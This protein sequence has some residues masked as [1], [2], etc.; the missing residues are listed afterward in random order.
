MKGY[1]GTPDCARIINTFHFA[2]ASLGAAL[3]YVRIQHRRHIP[4]REHEMSN[5][6]IK[7]LDHEIG[8]LVKMH[9]PEFATRDGKWLSYN[10][11]AC[12]LWQKRAH[13]N[14][15]DSA[16]TRSNGAYSR[17]HLVGA[18]ISTRLV[19]TRQRGFRQTHAER[20]EIAISVL[21]RERPTFPQPHLSRTQRKL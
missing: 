4:S 15:Q 14:W 6:E 10:T 20:D 8:P 11:I 2:I 7:R 18:H 13:K 12:S 16:S 21:T 19:E 3:L 1:S 17:D 5:E 9:I